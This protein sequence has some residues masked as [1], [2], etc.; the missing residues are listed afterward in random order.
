[1]ARPLA[2]E[3]FVY[4]KDPLHPDQHRLFRINNLLS[5]H[6]LRSVKLLMAYPP[7]MRAMGQLVGH[8]HFACR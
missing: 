3:T 4:Q 5:V 8:D 7:L 6:T 1:M 2:D